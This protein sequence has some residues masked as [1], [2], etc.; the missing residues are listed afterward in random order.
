MIRRAL[1]VCPFDERLYGALLEAAEVM[2]NRVG[3]GLAV[4]ELR[5]VTGDGGPPGTVASVRSGRVRWAPAAG[6]G[7]ARL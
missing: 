3:M 2:G 5:R 6:G 1:R 7:P 4:A